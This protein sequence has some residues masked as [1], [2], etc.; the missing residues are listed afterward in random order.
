MPKSQVIDP[1][2]APSSTHKTQ[3]MDWVEFV[4]RRLVVLNPLSSPAPELTTAS[5]RAGYPSILDL[6]EGW[7]R[8]LTRG[9]KALEACK[10]HQGIGVRVSM[11]EGQA[12]WRADQLSDWV[13]QGVIHQVLVDESEDWG[14]WSALRAQ[15]PD[16]NYQVWVEARTEAGAK[17]AAEDSRIAGV[18]LV[19]SEAVHKVNRCF[20]VHSGDNSFAMMQYRRY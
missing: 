9:L 5:K 13:A 14:A 4:Q 6:G 20:L 11:S 17:R 18:V 7:G 15:A 19:S 1:V 8:G 12:S 2:V 10:L 3:G 16:L